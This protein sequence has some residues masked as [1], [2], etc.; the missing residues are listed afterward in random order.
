MPIDTSIYNQIQQPKIQSPLNALAEI[1]QLRGLR[2]QNALADMKMGEYRRGV[3]ESNAERQA[4]ANNADPKAR[5]E[6]LAKVSPKGYQAEAKFQTEQQKSQREADKER[7][8]LSFQ[9]FEAADRITAGV[10][11]Q[12]GWTQAKQRAIQEFGPE[13]GAQIPDIYDPA[14]V[15]RKRMQAMDVKTRLKQEWDQKGYDLDVRKVDETRRNNNLVDARGR[16]A[17]A[18]KREE[19]EIKRGEKKETADMTKNSQIA[20]FDTML[21]TLD[22]LSKHPGLSRSVGLMGAIPSI[23]GSE[24]SNFGAEL[25]TFQSQAFIPMVAQLKGMGALSDSEGKKLTAAVGALDPKMG[26]K[27]FRESVARIIQ[28]M[29]AARE[30]L[31]GMPN[32]RKTETKPAASNIDDLLKK[33]GG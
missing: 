12:A 3:E 20:S 7:I 15:E 25:N 5:L 14:E 30:R 29:N 33:Y 16:E 13:V 26:E 18:A 24:A 10:K 19:N 31:S 23:P 9:R 6:A 2:S 28:D 27:A 22:R 32:T 4:Y 17:N 8:A 1:E 11:D 21:G